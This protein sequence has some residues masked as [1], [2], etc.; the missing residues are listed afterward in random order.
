MSRVTPAVSRRS[1][2][3]RAAALAVGAA[4]A[5][6]V[7]AKALAP[8]PAGRLFTDL[9][10]DPWSDY[11]PMRGRL[12]VRNCWASSAPSIAWPAPELITQ[13]PEGR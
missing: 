8:R 3:A 1:F 11:A 6:L 5:P 9:H 12:V 4:V 7:A 2:I 13:S 10:M